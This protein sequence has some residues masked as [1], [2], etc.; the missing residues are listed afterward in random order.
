MCVGVFA[1]VRAF[2]LCTF[3]VGIDFYVLISKKSFYSC[4]CDKKVIYV[5]VTCIRITP[6]R[7]H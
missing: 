1:C 4:V 3:E 2:F 6:L 7:N 5:V